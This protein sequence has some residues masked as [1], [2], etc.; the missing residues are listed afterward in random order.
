MKAIRVK[1]KTEKKNYSLNI[2]F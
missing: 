1:S 2:R